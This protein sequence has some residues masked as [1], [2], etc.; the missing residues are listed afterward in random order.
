M[1]IYY[2]LGG[3][4]TSIFSFS[5]LDTYVLL[6]KL[7]VAR[8]SRAS[9]VENEQ[10]IQC[11]RWRIAQEQSGVNENNGDPN[12]EEMEGGQSFRIGKI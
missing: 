6:K 8:P 3:S 7:T 9:L 1:L 10:M 5:T 12:L 2:S 4:S 11:L